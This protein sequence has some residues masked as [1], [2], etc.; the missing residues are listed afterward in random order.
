MTYVRLTI[1]QWHEI[2]IMCIHTYSDVPTQK[3]HFCQLPF[4]SGSKMISNSL[5]NSLWP[6]IKLLQVFG[7]CPIKKDEKSS[8]GF[9]AMHSGVYFI[10]VS[11][12]WL[13]AIASYCLYTNYLF[14]LY[15]INLEELSKIIYGF[16]QSPL[17]GTATYL[18][19]FASIAHLTIIFF[20]FKMKDKFIDLLLIFE[21]VK[22]QNN[23]PVKNKT[24]ILI[25][26]LFGSFSCSFV[27]FGTTMTLNE[28]FS[29]TIV[30]LIQFSVGLGI[31]VI[32]TT[33]P[34]FGLIIIYTE[35]CNQMNTW[36]QILSEDFNVKRQ[37][38]REQSYEH[39]LFIECLR[40]S[41]DMFSAVIFAMIT[42][43]LVYLIFAAYVALTCIITP[44]EERLWSQIT[45]LPALMS[46]FIYLYHFNSVS[47]ELTNN[48]QKLAK[49]LSKSEIC[50]ETKFYIIE[51][52]KSFQ[53]FD[54][55][56]FFTL[57]KPLLTSIAA[58]FA[59]FIIVLVQFKL[60]EMS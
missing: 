26:F 20:N 29:L 24:F 55:L 21:G 13:L 45:L 2:I 15:G 27:A 3:P 19:S 22:Q 40:K 12:A 37:S 18:L 60:T 59:T 34:V 31:T 35:V 25:N 10:I 43:Y 6:L 46:T 36:A 17:D 49:A 9:E 54:A 51:D 33:L 7:G 1:L 52:L 8:C 41:K 39:Q 44:S 42:W 4:E 5:F 14:S 53:G 57:G 58:N 30:H 48:V 56:G 16:D 50:F 47:H 28:K 11:I 23:R 32:I 38:W